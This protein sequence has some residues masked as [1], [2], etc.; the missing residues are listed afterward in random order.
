MFILGPQSERNGPTI[1]NE[2]EQTNATEKK[3]KRSKNKKRCSAVITISIVSI[4]MILLSPDTIYDQLYNVDQLFCKDGF[5]NSVNTSE[6]FNCKACEC[7]AISNVCSQTYD[8]RTSACY[9]Q[10]YCYKELRR[11]I[12]DTGRRNRR[13]VTCEGG[14]VPGCIGTLITTPPFKR[15]KIEKVGFGFSHHWNIKANK[16]NN[17]AITCYIKVVGT[18]CWKITDNYGYTEEFGIGDE[19]E[20]KIWYIKTIKTKKCT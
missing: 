15:G 19:K 18:C 5:Y 20:P 12:S 7:N 4:L 9:C 11:N 1:N 10:G 14:A 13:C 16:R 8:K 3:S 6:G 2:G 17:R